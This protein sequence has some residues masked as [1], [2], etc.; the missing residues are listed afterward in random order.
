[1]IVG[2][3]ELAQS[4]THQAIMAVLFPLIG[5]AVISSGEIVKTTGLPFTGVSANRWAMQEC[6]AAILAISWL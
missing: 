1:M 5:L 3:D 2:I 6:R 4:N